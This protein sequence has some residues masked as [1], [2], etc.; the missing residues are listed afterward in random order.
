MDGTQVNETVRKPRVIN[1]SIDNGVVTVTH[2]EH[3]EPLIRVDAEQLASTPS[4]HNLIAYGASVLL[5]QAAAGAEDPHAAVRDMVRKLAEGQWQP[6]RR[7]P[8]AQEVEP[9][10]EALAQQLGKDVAFIR[11]TYL[12]R[13]CQHQGFVASNG[14]LLMARAK[15]ELEKHPDL[16]PIIG[17]IMAKRAKDHKQAEH[18]DLGALA[19]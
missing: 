17:K 6:G 19:A 9:V 7:G 2:A 10:V 15:A 3:D 8:G 4:A 1:T 11:D 13:Y 5:R 12:P 16:A 18:V 14:R